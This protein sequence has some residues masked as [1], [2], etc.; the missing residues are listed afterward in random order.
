MSSANQKSLA[1]I[2]DLSPLI[3]GLACAALQPKLRSV[4][5]FDSTPVTLQ[6]A[7]AL[8][9]EM[10]TV[11]TEQTVKSVYV[12]LLDTE[13]TLWGNFAPIP[14]D[15]AQSFAWKPGLLGHPNET[16]LRLVVIPDLT[17]LSLATARACIALMGSEVAHLERH[18]QQEKWRSQLCWMAGC[19][20]SQV[21]FLSPHLLERFSLRLAGEDLPTGDR[22]QDLHNWF[23]SLTDLPVSVS[24]LSVE[25]RNRLQLAKQIHPT[26]SE[27]AY[28]QGL[29]Y[30][31]EPSGQGLRRELSLLRLAQAQVQLTGLERVTGMQVDRAAQLIGRKPPSIL[32]P[33]KS[34]PGESPPT[35]TE[36]AQTFPLSG[37]TQ[38]DP[39]STS[40]P[41]SEVYDSDGKAE[42]P[43]A[44]VNLDQQKDPYPEDNTTTEREAASLRLPPR[45][46][47]AGGRGT[48]IGIE[49]A[50]VLQDI[51][52]VSTLLEAAKY[53]AIRPRK[54]KTRLVLR[55]LDLRRYRRA[56][57]P[58]QMLM[59]VLDHTCLRDCQWQVVLLPYLQW[60]YV[61]RASVCLVQVGTVTQNLQAQKV[62]AQSVLVPRFQAALESGGGMATPLAHG[63]DLALQ[64]LRHALQ[65]GHSVVQR[66]MLVVLSDGR[67]NVPLEASQ[68]NQKPIKPVKRQ[69]IEDALDVAG[70]IR[71]L[72]QVE[73]VV[74]N[75]Q[76]KHYADLPVKLA[77]ALGA[78]IEAIP[79][80][81]PPWEVDRP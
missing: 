18:G 73:A 68:T 75:P 70:Q 64:T 25:L 60:A 37:L 14:A 39:I 47:W 63:L 46:F 66:A 23:A 21:K 36:S 16:A 2:A 22:T 61:E 4:V 50:T 20:R 17:R 52:W 1:A 29:T 48:I 57:V 41:K 72:R 49:A 35:L 40:A 9:A 7:A 8:W 43:P 45:R 62:M 5:V 32:P 44:Q 81:P 24:M 51:A 65:H 3:E 15:T 19:P 80:V 53:Q 12:G 71:Q 58:E 30:F 31:A 54:D 77:L 11:T 6:A 74:L 79:L 76:P 10:L 38:P 27:S 59:L 33:Q 26:I 55:S 56:A 34:S 28:Q 13:E 78:K 69:G 67:G 42:F